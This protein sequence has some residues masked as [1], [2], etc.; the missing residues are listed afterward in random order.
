MASLGN[1]IKEEKGETGGEGVDCQVLEDEEFELL[2][3]VTDLAT[4][5]SGRI[6]KTLIKLNVQSMHISN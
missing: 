5:E 6:V 2:C 4:L 3:H 1:I